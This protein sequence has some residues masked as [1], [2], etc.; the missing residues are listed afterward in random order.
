MSPRSTKPEH[1]VITPAPSVL[2]AVN[3][4]RAPA[5]VAQPERD[6]PQP[7]SERRALSPAPSVV[8]VTGSRETNVVEAPSKPAKPAKAAKVPK[9]AKAT[10]AAPKAAPAPVDDQPVDESELLSSTPV[11]E[12]SVGDLGHYVTRVMADARRAAAEFLASVDIDAARRAAIIRSQ[13]DAEATSMREAAIADAEKIRADARLE[14]DRLIAARLRLAIDLTDR[15]YG[16]ADQILAD[17]DR[18]DVA[19]RHLARFVTALTQTAE[20]AAAATD[21]ARG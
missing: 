9:A 10:K 4:S 7:V 20:H 14:G 15:L 13:A 11:D 2:D 12:S 8:V 1:L 3:A 19:R 16:Q 21:E 18:P 17:A 5:P 6:D